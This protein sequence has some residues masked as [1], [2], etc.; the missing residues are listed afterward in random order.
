[1]VNKWGQFWI[2]DNMLRVAKLGK[3][4]IQIFGS[5]VHFHMWEM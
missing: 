4:E 1:M 3:H 2:H 5:N